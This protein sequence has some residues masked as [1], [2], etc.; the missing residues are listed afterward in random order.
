MEEPK[1]LS[2]INIQYLNIRV[3]P[4]IIIRCSF[5]YLVMWIHLSHFKVRC[6]IDGMLQIESVSMAHGTRQCQQPCSFSSIL[7]QELWW[8]LML[9]EPSGDIEDSRGSL[10][11]T[12]DRVLSLTNS[13]ILQVLEFP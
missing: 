2:H 9:L 6:L 11:E 13:F 10:G 3:Q 8:L 5:I 12:G 1:C 4:K 7:E